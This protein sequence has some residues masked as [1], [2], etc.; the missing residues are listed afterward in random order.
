[1]RAR[2]RVR[3]HTDAQGTPENSARTRVKLRRVLL[4]VLVCR[5]NKYDT[6]GVAITLFVLGDAFLRSSMACY[7]YVSTVLHTSKIAVR[8]DRLSSTI[9]ASDRSTSD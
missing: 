1:M 2:A 7:V 4:T 6:G 8:P 5:E 3:T 9:R